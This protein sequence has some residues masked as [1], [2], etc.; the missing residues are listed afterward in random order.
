MVVVHKYYK[1]L[2]EMEYKLTD[3]FTPTTPAR[4]TFVNRSKIEKSLARA[5]RLPGKQIIVFGPSGSGKTTLLK[6]M[7]ENLN[8]PYI[9]T[10]C[11]RNI[12]LDNLK[13]ELLRKLDVSVVEKIEKTEGDEIGGE[14]SGGFMGIGAKANSKLT[15]SNKSTIKTLG[16]ESLSV[17]KLIE[18]LG[19]RK[20]CWLIEDFHKIDESN[21]VDFSQL[22]KIFMDAADTYPEVKIIAIGAVNSAREVVSY[23]SELNNRV[24][25]IQVPLLLD[26][27]LESIINKGCDLL[28][29]Y[30]KEPVKNK[31]IG[32][33]YGL[34]SVTHYL[35]YSSCEEM[36]VIKTQTIKGIDEDIDESEEIQNVNIRKEIPDSALQEAINSYIF[37]KSD[38]YKQIYNKATKIVSKRNYDNPIDI[39]NAVLELRMKDGSTVQEIKSHIKRRYRTYRGNKL[40]QYLFEL[41]NS[42]RGEILR[43]DK[44]SDRFSFS[45]PFIQAFAYCKKNETIGTEYVISKNQLV[46]ELERTLREELLNAR[47]QF[48]EDYDTEF[49][50]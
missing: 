43:Y 22:M 20:L 29:I 35:C 34:P 14:V 18:E 32:Y 5:L 10:P 24:A 50:L 8:R 46:E 21:K 47:D 39:I 42:N 25:E 13:S 17:G 23:E 16:S 15:G 2:N 3:V 26:T 27:E 11:N 1:E 36:E 9:S 30:F 6:N 37:E 4:L 40:R 33:S 12:T 45:N 28:N 19:K 41:T 31:I 44:D 48:L 38:S 49:D 7:F